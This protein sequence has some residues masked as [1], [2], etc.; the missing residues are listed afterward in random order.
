MVAQRTHDQIGCARG[1][2]RRYRQR[3]GRHGI[4]R[5]RRCESGPRPV[6][7]PG[8]Q[9]LRR[10]VHQHPTHGG[11]HDERLRT[12]RR[13]R[14]DRYSRAGPGLGG[15]AADLP[16][17]CR[18]GARG[19]AEIGQVHAFRVAFGDDRLPDRHRA[20][21]RVRPAPRPGGDGRVRIDRTRQ[22]RVRG[23]P[24]RGDRLAVAA[25]RRQRAGDRMGSGA[26]QGPAVRLAGR[27]TDTERPHADLRL[28][29]RPPRLRC[30]RHP[31]GL[32]RAP[33]A[34]PHGA[35]TVA[36]RRSP[37]RHG[38]RARPGRGSRRG[39]AESRRLTLDAQ[40]GFHGPGHRQRRRVTGA[41]HA[42]RRI[43]GADRAQPCRG[44][45][46][47]LGRDLVRNLAARPP[48]RLRRSGRTGADADPG[49]RPDHRLGRL[50]GTVPG[51]GHLEQRIH[52]ADRLRHDRR[53]RCSCR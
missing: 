15:G 30:G 46:D 19:G 40:P 12:R 35:D 53:R 2:T 7:E 14:P 36:H 42:G 45:R 48:G 10:L 41:R 31:L 24:S 9:D 44:R 38:D 47:P 25:G 18:H 13:I 26:D 6:R 28:G 50:P 3:A 29:H 23:D 39:R 20:Q 8:G 34:E 11:H 33:P 49:R 21:Y 4:G 17:R 5:T 51:Q 43:G 16:R 37:G 22:S 1:T 52:V 32:S 27:P